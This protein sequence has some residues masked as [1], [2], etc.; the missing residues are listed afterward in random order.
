MK[1]ISAISNQIKNHTFSYTGKGAFEAIANKHK[2]QILL[3][4]EELTPLQVQIQMLDELEN[5][6][7]QKRN[8]TRILTKLFPKEYTEFVSLNILVRDS[9]TIAR[10]YKDTYDLSSL[11]DSLIKDKF[12]KYPGKYD[13]YVEFDLFQKFIMTYKEDLIKSAQNETIPDNI[14]IHEVPLERI[15]IL[16]PENKEE[17]REEEPI[18]TEDQRENLLKMQKTAED[19]NAKI[20]AQKK[21]KNTNWTNLLLGK[22]K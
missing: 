13:K 11:Y 20:E 12:L 4:L 17:I 22:L 1:R 2:E 3:W 6:S 19:E 8:Y 18:E 14:T 15:N 9:E 7:F 16:K 5:V 10:Y 21:E